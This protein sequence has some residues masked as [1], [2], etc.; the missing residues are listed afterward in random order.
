MKP[1]LPMDYRHCQSNAGCVDSD[2]KNK[3]VGLV[4]YKHVVRFCYAIEFCKVLSST[5]L[6]C[7]DLCRRRPALQSTC[8]AF[9]D[10]QVGPQ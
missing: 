7:L 4:M 3:Q 6:I 1:P 5:P 8:S 10:V 9:G 2:N